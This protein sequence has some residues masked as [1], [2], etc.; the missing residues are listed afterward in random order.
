MQYL[1][2]SR[3]KMCPRMVTKGQGPLCVAALCELTDM[4]KVR[5]FFIVQSFSCFVFKVKKKKKKWCSRCKG[6][7]KQE[8]WLFCN[9]HPEKRVFVNFF[10]T[11]FYLLFQECFDFQ[12][13]TSI[14]KSH[15]YYSE[16]GIKNKILRN[17]LNFHDDNY[18]SCVDHLYTR[19][20]I[21]LLLEKYIFIENYF[22]YMY[23]TINQFSRLPKYS[24]FVLNAHDHEYIYFHFKI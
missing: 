23:Y 15:N 9:R 13:A 11:R 8:G 5:V 14:K 20:G 16:G 2:D 12:C 22:Q 17:K 10:W 7:S 21:P 4:F 3:R 19:V 6:D 1:L 18:L 24:E